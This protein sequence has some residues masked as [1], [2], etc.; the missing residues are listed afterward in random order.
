MMEDPIHGRPL[1]AAGPITIAEDQWCSLLRVV[2]GAVT[3]ATHSVMERDLQKHMKQL[4]D[5]LTIELELNRPN[6]LWI[7]KPKCDS[8]EVDKSNDSVQITVPTT[9]CRQIAPV[10]PS[11]SDMK[12]PYPLPKPLHVAEGPL[13]EIV[14]EGDDV[15]ETTKMA[16][17]KMEQDGPLSPSSSQKKEQEQP[18][19]V[20]GTP[21]LK[22]ST[23]FTKDAGEAKAE[24]KKHHASLRLWREDLVHATEDSVLE[25]MVLRL[26]EFCMSLEEPERTGHLADFVRSR[27]FDIVSTTVILFNAIF[28]AY[29]ANYDIQHIEAGPTAFILDAERFFACFFTL[30]LVLKLMVHKAYFFVNDHM[31]WNIFDLLLVALAVYE[32]LMTITADRGEGGGGDNLT[33]MRAL[34]V[35]KMAKMMR[36][37]KLLKSFRDLR[38]MLMCIAGSLVSLF[39][40]FVMLGF[41]LFMFALFFVQGFTS[42]LSEQQVDDDTRAT[43]MGR[44]GSVQSAV[45]TLY[46]HVTGGPGWEE[47]YDILVLTGPL[48]SLGLVF[49]VGF[50]QFAVFNILTGLFVEHA[51]KCAQPDKDELIL[52]QRKS[53]LEDKDA[54]EE[55][56]CELDADGSGSI[57][58][59]EFDR[60][61]RTPKGRHFLKFQGLDV[62]DAETFFQLISTATDSEGVDVRAFA[63]CILKMRGPASSMDMQIVHYETKMLARRTAKFESET[64]RVLKKVLNSLDGVQAKLQLA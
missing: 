62:E 25:A 14:N 50:F 54:M 39:W 42:L 46:Q 10:L 34:R 36:L 40:V 33:F 7:G 59:E 35:L 51:M 12:Q 8:Q 27:S 2:E 44:Y 22:A 19:E 43:V 28:M 53:E 23:T 61:I 48:Y 45:L 18:E 3:A 31:K 47:S 13:L 41:V 57:T 21:P 56:C 1:E 20:N 55:L 58:L 16:Q 26:V 63:D 4:Q 29:S 60:H 17:P 32:Q 64:S 11:A 9:V 49:F 30:E 38:V 52:E 5:L 6:K 15:V 37:A 24:G